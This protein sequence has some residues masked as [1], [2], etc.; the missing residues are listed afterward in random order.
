MT[1]KDIVV[2]RELA[3]KMAKAGFPQEGG[4]WYWVD[5][6]INKSKL[7]KEEEINK[8][9]HYYYRAPTFSEIWQ[10]LPDS[11]ER[12]W[13]IVSESGIIL[14][15]EVEWDYLELHK[16]DGNDGVEIGYYP[17]EGKI[18]I[19]IHNKRPEDAAAELWL[20]VREN[21]YGAK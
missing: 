21:G 14:R 4:I 8:L 1:P 13:N 20:W 17:F 9:F 10:E 12:K 18:P 16:L 7:I 19:Q 15:T 2:I 3:E 5:D 6:K 11:I